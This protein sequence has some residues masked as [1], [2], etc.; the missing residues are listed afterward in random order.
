MAKIALGSRKEV[1]DPEFPRSVFTEL[2]LTFI[3]VFTGVGAAMSAGN[4]I[5]LIV[6]LI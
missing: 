2:L 6:Q 3:F 1:E 4:F 5:F